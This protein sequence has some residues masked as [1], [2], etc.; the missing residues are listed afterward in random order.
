M[1]VAK[2]KPSSVTSLFTT[3]PGDITLRQTQAKLVTFLAEND[4]ALSVVDDLVSLVKSLP[5][6]N[7]I[8]KLRLDKQKATNLVRQGLAPYFKD[9]LAD[10]SKEKPFSIIIDET[11]D[12]GTTKQLCWFFFFNKKLEMEFDLLDLIEYMA[13]QA[14]F[15]LN[16]RNA[17]M[18]L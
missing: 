4:I 10:T 5:H 3:T 2:E 15:F 16:S 7:V 6:K 13:Q 8:E 17:W 14:H 11:T 9:K 12:I 1:T 18:V